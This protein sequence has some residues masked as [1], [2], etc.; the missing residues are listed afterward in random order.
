MLHRFDYRPLGWIILII[1]LTIG[2]CLTP[3]NI[4]TAVCGVVMI[5]SN[6]TPPQRETIVHHYHHG[7][8]E[9]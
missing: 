3:V 4:L 5:F 2:W 6:Y 7:G 8:K 9:K 1:S